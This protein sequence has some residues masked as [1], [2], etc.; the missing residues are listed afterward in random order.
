MQRRDRR[1]ASEIGP[2][3][4]QVMNL[5][6][7]R[8]MY[9]TWALGSAIPSTPELMK[10]T[11]KSITPVRRAV[12]RL[13]ADGILEGHPGKGVFVKALPEDA[14]RERADA[15]ALGEQ[16]AELRQEVRELAKQADSDDLRDRLGRLE[17]RVGRVEAA[18]AT[19]FKRAAQP[20]PLGG[21]HDGPEKAA[22]HGRPGRR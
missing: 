14:D 3:Y 22:G 6:R 10:L 20:N 5:I 8:I 19:F 15:E 17:T 16:F 2:D 7:E 12:Q 1:L 9:G 13:E 11:G 21:E 4:R 18:I